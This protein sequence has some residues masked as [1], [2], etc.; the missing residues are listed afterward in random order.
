[1]AV[2]SFINKYLVVF[3]LFGIISYP[4]EVNIQNKCLK[5]LLQAFQFLPALCLCS[6]NIL[7]LYIYGSNFMTFES[8]IRPYNDIL[9]IILS[10]FL[11]FLSNMSAVIL[12]IYHR[13]TFKTILIFLT[14]LE[15]ILLTNIV[16]YELTFNRMKKK[17]NKK[18]FYIVIG[19]IILLKFN[20]LAHSYFGFANIIIMVLITIM[21]NILYLSCF[22][23][24]V[25]IDAISFMLEHM[26]E[27]FQTKSE[28]SF[29]KVTDDLYQNNDNSALIID[30]LKFTK[31]FYYN[32][33]QCVEM[34]NK[35]F[36]WIFMI[37]LMHMFME[38]TLSCFLIFI[39]FYN[40]D[41]GFSFF[42][43]KLFYI[44]Y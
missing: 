43:R 34:V 41:G 40:I 39:G 11:L 23:A 31:Y 37:S 8:V 32:V 22:N 35:Y 1:M 44:L 3:Y 30:H 33:Y 6:F 26:N 38:I 12:G 13:K 15:S 36:G 2:Q 5:I 29:I 14:N 10:F 20:I 4:F 27:K 17:V 25:H 18:I 19:E 16:D 9:L 7:T 21:R 24:I 42:L 28:I